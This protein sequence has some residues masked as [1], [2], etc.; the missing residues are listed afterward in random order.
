MPEN[1]SE[2]EIY[3]WNQYVVELHLLCTRDN[4]IDIIYV[5]DGV[6][7]FEHAEKKGTIIT[8]P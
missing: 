6:S 5:M 8:I 4:F 7:L 2:V 1:E 3:G